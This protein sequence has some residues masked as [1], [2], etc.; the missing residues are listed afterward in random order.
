MTGTASAHTTSD[1]DLWTDVCRGDVTAFETVVRRHQSA[2]AAVA[3]ALCG[4]RNTSEDITQETFW[5]SWKDRDSLQQPDRLRAWLC[6]IARNLT[7]QSLRSR[8]QRT[9]TLGIDPEA[10]HFDPETSAISEEEEDLVWRSLEEIP[11]T[12][13]EPLV[14][15]YREQQSV[16]EVA[17]ALDVSVDAVKQRLSRGR[18]MLREQVEHVIEGTLRRT[19]PGAALTVAI[20]TGLASHKAAWAATA[21]ATGATLGKA[22]TVS[23]VGAIAGPVIGAAGGL[24]G[25]WLGTWIPSQMAATNREREFIRRAGL[26]ILLI[27]LLFTLGILLTNLLPLVLPMSRLLITLI[28][29]GNVTTTAAFI[30]WIFMGAARM[31]RQLR[32]LRAETPPGTDENNTAMRRNVK[33]ICRRWRGR[34]WQSSWKLFGL[35]L[36]DIHVS[37]PQP[38][39]VQTNPLIPPTPRCALGWIAIGDEARGVLLALGNKAYGGIAFGGIAVGVI[40]CGGIAVGGLALGGM[41]FGIIAYG[42]GAVGGLAL[43]GVGLGYQAAGGLAVAWDVAVGGLALAQ[44]AAFGGCAMARDLAVGG[45]AQAL[46]ANDAVAEAVLLNHPLKRG[47]DWYTEHNALM[48]VVILVISLSPTLLSW[49]LLY[50]RA[51]TEEQRADE[52]ASTTATSAT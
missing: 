17:S 5:I 22:A 52:T 30:I 18:A 19:R 51:T 11:E 7:R 37:D 42:G 14:L 33:A 1:A 41:A 27:S 10:S 2:V 36:I 23:S 24:A 49:P 31:N 50:R 47:M 46:H 25:A 32:Q 20:M 28:V 45:A 38:A 40:A 6:G 8:P 4:D 34:V 12:Y 21:S 44:H 26:R 9:T 29:I 15:F 43:G 39:A 35:P 3:F 16:A 48:I 13:R